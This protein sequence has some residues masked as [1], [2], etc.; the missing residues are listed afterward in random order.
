[1]IITLIPGNKASIMDHYNTPKM[2]PYTFIIAC[3]AVLKN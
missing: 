1:M 2:D 3:V